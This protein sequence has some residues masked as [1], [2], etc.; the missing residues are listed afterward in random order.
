MVALTTVLAPPR[1]SKGIDGTLAREREEPQETKTT[2]LLLPPDSSSGG[3]RMKDERDHHD[4]FY[5]T[6][7]VIVRVV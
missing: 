4:S 1:R 3:W 2:L 7:Y 6:G 5:R